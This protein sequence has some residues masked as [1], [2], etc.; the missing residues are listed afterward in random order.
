[1]LQDLSVQISRAS[2]INHL[3]P[4]V[5]HS[6]NDKHYYIFLLFQIS[7]VGVH[8]IICRRLKNM[9]ISEEIPQLLEVMLKGHF[10]YNL[11]PQDC[12]SSPISYPIYDLLIYNARKDRNFRIALFLRLKSI[13][14]TVDE[15]KA[16]FCYYLC[17]DII[18]INSREA[19]RNIGIIGKRYKHTKMLKSLLN[20]RFGRTRRLYMLRTR[21]FSIFKK[22]KSPTL[23]GVM[24]YFVKA[25][26]APFKT[27][28]FR[29]IDEY[30]KIFNSKKTYKHL[31]LKGINSRFKENCHFLEYMVDISSNLKKM[32][33]NL[34]QRTLRIHLEILNRE[35]SGRVVNPFQPSKSILNFNLGSAKVLD[36]AEN[37][38]YI[39]VCECADMNTVRRPAKDIKR[40]KAL[41]RQLESLNDLGELGDIN[42]IKTSLVVAIE[43][44]LFPQEQQC[45]TIESINTQVSKSFSQEEAV[46]GVVNEEINAG[47]K[48][49]TPNDT[50]KTIDEIVKSTEPSTAIQKYPLTYE[51]LVDE[52]YAS[53]R[54]EDLLSLNTET[55]FSSFRQQLHKTSQYTS[56]P[57]WCL[58]SFIVKSGNVLKHEYLAYQVLTQMKEIFLIEN[59]PIYIRNYK[60]ILVSDTAGFVETVTD[61]QSIHRLKFDSKFKTLLSYF[62]FLFPGERF[63]IAKK[64]FL[65]SLVGCSLAS[66]ILQIKDRHNG[67]ILIDG[68]GHIIHVDFGFTFGKRPG[69]FIPLEN[70]PFKFSS[71]YLELLDLEEFK[72]LFTN[73]FKALRKNNEKL[74]RLVEI[75]QDSGYYDKI[76]YS[77]FV[78]RLRLSDSEKDLELFCDG[79]IDRS[80]R[81]VLTMVYDQFQYF[82][83]GYL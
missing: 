7:S 77:E 35:M 54:S 72:K 74:T 52:I 32:P 39:V 28:V 42:G 66:Y 24:L 75:M 19:K 9:D 70:A 62:K 16:C 73:G 2:N 15:S 63:Q 71:E 29:Y 78:D 36:S 26:L 82:S 76:A 12:T 13:L 10:Q 30:S 18:A 22:Q 41:V 48:N 80:I 57:G 40:V 44:A 55:S 14:G 64:N 68:F 79:L 81:S 4:L 53:D 1:M 43:N 21:T 50:K 67:N 56:C 61:A 60:I 51:R 38:P 47:N 37:C 31:N 33:V 27:D 34:R 11:C 69:W 46:S 8:Y 83:N 6:S 59:L 5:L 65:H 58:S 49:N 45:N 25:V 3:A 20:R 23:N 17:C